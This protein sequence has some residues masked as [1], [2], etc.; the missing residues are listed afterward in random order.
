MG[1]HPIFESDFDCLTDLKMDRKLIKGTEIGMANLVDAALQI[2]SVFDR[3]DIKSLQQDNEK[4]REKLRHFTRVDE[5]KSDELKAKNDDISALQKELSNTKHRF[6]EQKTDRVQEMTEMKEKLNEKT[7]ELERLLAER[8]KDDKVDQ[9]YE[10]QLEIN[11]KE[12]EFLREE[13]SSARS[14]IVDLQD[15]VVQEEVLKHKEEV[16]EKIRRQAELEKEHSQNWRRELKKV[17]VMEKEL[18]QLRLENRELG[19][20]A[21]DKSVAIEKEKLWRSTVN[22]I[23]PKCDALEEENERLQGDVLR[24]NEKIKRLEAELNEMRLAALQNSSEIGAVRAS[25]AVEQS[26]VLAAQA[27][28]ED[29]RKELETKKADISLAQSAIQGDVD[30]SALR[31]QIK[32]MEDENLVLKAEIGRYRA[33]GNY[34]S[35]KECVLS[36]RFNPTGSRAKK[37][38]RETEITETSDG[39]VQSEQLKEM[40]EKYFFEKKAKEKVL[41]VVK[42]RIESFREAIAIILG[43]QVTT[44]D[45]QKFKFLS[46]FAQRREDYIQFEKHEENGDV[47]FRLFGSTL[48]EN[49][50]LHD[51]VQDLE[52]DQNVPSMMSK[53]TLALAAQQTLMI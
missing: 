23:Q 24:C 30:V 26:R 8:R 48:F 18:D 28:V 50:E 52:T 31:D 46:T 39:A 9:N 27:T 32:Q 5:K 35:S 7:D 22:R 43:Y 12:L 14:R 3:D 6:Y 2:L 34:D 16:A 19:R 33:V 49:P 44:N 1:T 21:K 4:L 29:L 20:Q 15:Q 51:L 47:S 40:T 53:T 38:P 41:E 17:K 11:Q 10:K 13:L 42:T 37:R 25:L 45:Y 36:Y